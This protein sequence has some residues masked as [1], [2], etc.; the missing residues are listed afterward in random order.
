MHRK[1][2]LSCRYDFIWGK[3]KSV[4]SVR[5][6]IKFFVKTS[7]WVFGAQLP[8]REY[9]RE[10]SR[11]RFF[12]VPQ[13]AGVQTPKLLEALLVPETVKHIVGIAIHASFSCRAD[14]SLLTEQFS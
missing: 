6:D 11:S 2:L 5:K 10:L 12:L 1:V 4:Q 9:W 14:D 13:G 8:P 7:C 3:Q